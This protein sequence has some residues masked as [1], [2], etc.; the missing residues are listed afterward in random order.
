MQWENSLYRVTV[1]PNLQLDLNQIGVIQ[2]N[3]RMNDEA[4]AGAI[5]MATNLFGKDRESHL[6]LEIWT[7][8]LPVV[9]QFHGSTIQVSNDIQSIH[10]SMYPAFLRQ[11]V[12]FV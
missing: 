12:P 6:R 7:G 10:P 3:V 8:N 4:T 2:Q 9:T 1:Q 5:W 11:W